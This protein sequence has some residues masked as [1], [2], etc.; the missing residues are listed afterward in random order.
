MTELD[1][2]LRARSLLE[3]P[4][5]RVADAADRPVA[6]SSPSVFSA[7]ALSGVMAVLVLSTA[8][9]VIFAPAPPTG[10]SRR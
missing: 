3:E 2:L 5:V 8:A 6:S 1:A 7:L 9:V 10:T 4:E